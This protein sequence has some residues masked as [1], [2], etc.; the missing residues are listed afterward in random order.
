MRCLLVEDDA[1][2]ARWLV[3]SLAG[4]NIHAD[5]EDS[6]R[7]AARRGL[8]DYDAI[9]LDL[10][11][12]DLDGAEVLA[13]IRAMGG[14]LPILILTARDD[15]TER[16]GLLHAGADDFLTKPFELSELEARLVAL[17]RRS[18]G[19]ATGRFSCGPLLYDDPT[20]RFHLA[21]DPLH[22]TPR[23]HALLRLLIQ[24][25]GEP[26]SKSHLLD[27]MVGEHD[28]LNPEAIEVLIHRLRR[29]LDGHP[30]QIV[31]LRGLGYFL[32]AGDG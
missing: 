25:V 16:V 10:G 28:D 30:V 7:I 21:G 15:L 19:R 22:V 13:R 11:L 9:L 29:K 31:T 27:R 24:R 12:P 3:R 18:H 26:M 32:E 8:E 1:D 6:G 17:V 5:W 23:E 2:L 14:T 20:R 4:L